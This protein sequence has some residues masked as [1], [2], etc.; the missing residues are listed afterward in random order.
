MVMSFVFH[1]IKKIHRLAE[2]MLAY[3]EGLCC[4]EMMMT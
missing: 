2:K 3:R 1:K 4:K